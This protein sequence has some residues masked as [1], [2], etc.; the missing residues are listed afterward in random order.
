MEITAATRLGI[1]SKRLWMCSWSTADQA[2]STRC[3]SRSGVA[4]GGVIWVNFDQPWTTCFP[5]A[6]DPERES[7]REAIQSG[8]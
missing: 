7:V 5:S 4:A 1:D 3:Q 8:G 2:T 6:K